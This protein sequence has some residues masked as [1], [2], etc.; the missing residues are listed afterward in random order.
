ML[1]NQ[2]KRHLKALAHPKKPVVIVGGNGLTQAV[3]AE[4]DLALDCHELIKVR[5]N[6]DDRAAR[7]EIAEQISSRLEAEFV[8]KVGHIATLFRRNPKA[9]RIHFTHS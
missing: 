3:L 1:S 7:Q 5:I 6:A 2:Q 9:P 4:I 8:Q